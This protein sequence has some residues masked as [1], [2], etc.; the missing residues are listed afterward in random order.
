MTVTSL[1]LENFRNY[2]ELD[3]KLG[4]GINILCGENGHGKTNLLEALYFF[5][6]AKSFRGAQEKDIISLGK[7]GFRI[8]LEFEGSGRDKNISFSYNTGKKRKIILN[9]V[10]KNKRAD[11]IGQFRAVVFTPD[12]LSLVKGGPAERRRFIDTGLCQIR[13]AYFSGLLK[14]QK[15]LAQKLAL[16]KRAGGA[17]KTIIDIINCELSQVCGFIIK[18]RAEY[19]KKI[20]GLAKIRHNEISEGAEAL[21]ISYYPF[22]RGEDFENADE[23]AK[24]CYERL[25]GGMSAEIAAGGCLYGTHRDG[26]ELFI[27]SQNARIF[28]S[29]GQQRSIV[30]SLKSAECEMLRGDDGEYPVLLLDDMLSELDRRRQEYI[31]NHTGAGQVIITCCDKTQL[32]KMAAGGSRMFLIKDGKVKKSAR[33]G[34]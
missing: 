30:L 16:L 10:E 34:F 29:Q 25:S 26:I 21:A 31:L 27:N 12:H 14:A 9:G 18:N 15:L 7:E 11:I 24:R 2:K 19:I 3:I 17:D 32:E 1:F 23:I 22:C 13:P 20:E 5:T 6:T 8:G 33:K 4:R 28:A